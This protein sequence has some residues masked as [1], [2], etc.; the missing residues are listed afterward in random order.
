MYTMIGIP[1]N[2]RLNWAECDPINSHNF[3]FQSDL[4][5][6]F[7]EFEIK[8]HHR[9]KEKKNDNDNLV[10]PAQMIRRMNQL[11]KMTS[12]FIWWNQNRSILYIRQRWTPTTNI[13]FKI[14]GN[15]IKKKNKKPFQK[16][17]S[18]QQACCRYIW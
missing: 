1:N 6:T 4:N 5:K 12:K 15:L 18:F 9:K 8:N 13:K 14:E 16:R 2:H 17:M 11:K 10:K 3:P 7:S